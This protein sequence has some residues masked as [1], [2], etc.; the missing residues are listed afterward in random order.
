MVRMKNLNFYQKGILLVMIVMTIVFAVIYPKV[1][2]RVGYRFNDAILVPAEENGITTY[3]GKI[4]REYVV[5][6][7]SD[8]HTVE[9]HYGE[10]NHGKYVLKDDPAAIPKDRELQEQMTGIEITNSDEIVFRGGVLDF[11]DDFYLYNEDGTLDN[12]GFSYVTSDGIERDETGN[13]IDVM[14]PSAST[15]YELLNDPELTHKGDMLAWYGGLF[16]GIL[17][18]I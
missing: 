13:A 18:E 6:R 5:F 8:D 14:E 1:I 3:S 11:G 9:F 15:I 7:V 4:K 16:I 10:K 17:N 2:A 12:F